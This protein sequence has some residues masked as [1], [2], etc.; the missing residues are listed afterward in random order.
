MTD[1]VAKTAIDQKIA[2]IVRP[3]IEGMGYELVRL[4][5]M[6]GNTP[7]L[8]IMAEKPEGISV[9]ASTDVG[10]VQIVVSN[11]RN[12][13]RILSDTGIPFTVQDVV[14]LPLRHAPGSLAEL[15]GRLSKAKIN[16]N[17]VYATGCTCGEDC[18]CFAVV[19]APDLERVEEIWRSSG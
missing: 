11:A 13:R 18:R 2:E 19:S 17:Y 16:V 12:T 14:L 5:L 3:V 9:S 6:G 8:Q 7:T 1:L 10:L 15:M 4:R